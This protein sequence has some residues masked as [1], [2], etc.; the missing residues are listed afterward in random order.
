MS[1]LFAAECNR[2]GCYLLLSLPQSNAPATT[3]HVPSVCWPI[4]TVA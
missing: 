3:H 4:G 1:R 2:G